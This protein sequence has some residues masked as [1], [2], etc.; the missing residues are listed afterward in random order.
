MSGMVSSALCCAGN[1]LC[2]C[3]SNICSDTMKI[4]PK[5]FSRIGFIFL[6]IIAVIISLVILFFAANILSPF[7]KFIHCPNITDADEKFN[8]LGISSVYRMSVSLAFLHALVL[9]FCLF[10]KGCAKAINNDCWTF[11]FLCVFG[12]Y[13]GLFFVSNDFFRIYAEISIYVSLLFQLYQVIVIISFAHI[14]NLKLADG[15]DNAYDN[16]GDGACKYQFW[17]IF[18]T[19]IFS[20]VSLFFI[21]VSFMYFLNSAFNMFFIIL[22]IVLGIIFTGISISNLVNKKR[23]LTSIYLFSYICYIC[24]S[25]LNSQPKDEVKKEEKLSKISIID[26]LIGFSYLL[27]ALFFLGFYIKKAPQQ[28]IEP[29]NDNSEQE[30]INKNPM[31]E[32]EEGKQFIFIFFNSK[33]KTE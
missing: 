2:Q 15:L 20:G 31:L 17:L 4:N 28:K 29:N 10:G 6:N 27:G 11:K 33:R 30:A 21:I 7:E 1:C 8:C 9:L 23:L 13:F 24:W 26:I 5:L 16:G 32:Q 14:I 12:V 25:A 22:T 18:L 19:L 3:V